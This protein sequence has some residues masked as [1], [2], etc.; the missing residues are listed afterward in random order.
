M[1][2]PNVLTTRHIPILGIDLI[3][4]AGYEVTVCE[5]DR[6]LSRE[7][8]LEA[9]AGKDGILCLLHDK[10][11]AE[12]ITAAD[13]ARVFSNYAVGYNNI[14][15]ESC[16]ARGIRVTNTPG[17]LTEAT[18]DLAWCLILATARRAAEAD[19]YV[20]AGQWAGWGPEQFL[21]R[22]I[23]GKTLGI[24][25]A[26]R[27]GRAVA[28]RA[29]AFRMQV[30]YT[31]GEGKPELKD[32]EQDLDA[33]LVTLDE[34]LAESD[35]VSIHCP[36]SPVTHH[37]IGADQ[38]HQMKK[39]G[40]LINTARGP[41]VDEAALVEALRN[42][43]IWGAGLD[44]YE[45]EPAIAP[46]LIDLPNAV[47]LPHLGSATIDTRNAMARLAALNLIAV[48]EGKEPLHAVV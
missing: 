20:R 27:I 47:L 22:D 4:K 13:K 32:W 18:A 34:L 38:M 28:E 2:Q 19:Q 24:I 6:P 11:D 12:V 46:G 23:S 25:G 26:G 45:E 8:L 43:V 29:R 16:K 39:T 37:L 33:R 35:Y 7:E 5:Q 42:G 14:D 9:V 41:I 21:G 10:I 31:R 3:R 30:V 15:T 44:V 17:V 1:A 36:Y 40:I 48:L